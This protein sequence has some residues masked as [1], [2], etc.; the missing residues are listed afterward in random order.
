[1]MTRLFSLLALC[2]IALPAFAQE[3]TLVGEG[4]H[5]SGFGGPALKVTRFNDKDVL[6][7]GAGGAWYINH[8]LGLGI[9]GYRMST[10]M[11]GPTGDSSRILEFGYGGGTVEY[12]ICSE[13]LLHFSVT[14][15]IGA[16]ALS[17]SFRH[18]NLGEKDS[19]GP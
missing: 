13:N 16:G 15:L 12:V 18:S 8:T 7:V 6:M 19:W 14:T 10:N 1:M 11:T 4:F 2:L 5:S 9:A 3:Q 17:Y